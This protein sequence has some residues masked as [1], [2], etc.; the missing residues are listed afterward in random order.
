MN[1]AYIYDRSKRCRLNPD[2]FARTRNPFHSYENE[3]TYKSMLPIAQQL[4]Q[5]SGTRFSVRY[6][7]KHYQTPEALQ[8]KLSWLR[9]CNGSVG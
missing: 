7:I 3:M 6:L 2:Q 5:V 4:K 1:A 8:K 9:G